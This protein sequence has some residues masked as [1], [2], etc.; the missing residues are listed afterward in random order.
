L[1]SKFNIRGT[2]GDIVAER[3][4]PIWTTVGNLPIEYT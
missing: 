3:K 1:K 4:N 2:S